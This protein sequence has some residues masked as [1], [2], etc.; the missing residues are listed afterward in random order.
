MKTGIINH[1]MYIQPFFFQLCYNALFAEMYITTLN[2]ELCTEQVFRSLSIASLS[3]NS[4]DKATRR[5]VLFCT[6]K[7][8]YP[9]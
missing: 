7:R 6:S 3:E 1:C 9:L 5:S 2:Q 8:P 4:L